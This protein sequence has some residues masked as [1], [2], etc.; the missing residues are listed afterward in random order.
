MSAFISKK[1]SLVLLLCAF[2]AAAVIVLLL[3][4]TLAGPK[5]GPIYDIL[6]GFRPS[7]PVSNDILLIETDEIIEP[8]DVFSVL[9][10]LSEMG[11]SDLLI[12]VPVLGTSSGG[13]AN[14]TELGYQISDEFNLLGRNIRNLF[15]A[16][17]M[18]L[19]SPLESP[20]F[21]ESVVELAERGRDRLNAAAIRQDEEGS[22]RAGQAA[23]VFGRVASAADLRPQPSGDIPWYSRPV[24][25]PDR[26]LRRI[27]PITAEG[28]EHIAYRALASRW[29]ES[30]VEHTE[31]GMVLVNRF[32]FQGE[33]IEYRF[34]LD[35]GGNLLFERPHKNSGFRRLP[36]ELFSEYDRTDRAMARLLKEAE[37][38]GAYSETTPEDI[39]SILYEFTDIKKEDLLQKPDD[40]MRA[41]WIRSRME[42][43]ASLEEFLYGPSEM[44]LVNGYEELI[45]GEG[46]EEEG[47]VK[48]QGLRDE[49]IRAFVGMREKHRELTDLRAL[50]A[51]ELNSSFCIMGPSFSVSEGE[52]PVATTPLA[53]ARP[54]GSGGAIPESS[55]L[56]A[57]ALLNG[58]SVTP[59]QM[60]YIVFWSLVA[61]LAVLV[62]IHAL[63]PLPLLLT[64]LAASL[65]CGLSF[66]V[67]FVAGGYWIDPLIPA[68]ACLGGTLVLAVS[69]FCIGYD[70]TL[71]FRLAYASSVNRDALKLLVKTGRPALAET[72]TA[73]AAIIAVKNQ[74]LSVI[75]DREQPLEAAVVTGEFRETFSAY[76]KNAGAQL[77]GFEG[78][79]ALACFG[80]PLDNCRDGT[81]PA[82]RA[83]QCVTKLLGDPMFDE[84]R[85]GVESGECTFSWSAETGYTA[86][87]RAAVRARIFSALAIR[88][89]AK[90]IIGEAARE[91]IG[92]KLRKLSSLGDSA[93]S[94]AAVSENFYELK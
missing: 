64:G 79:I 21:V 46:H 70:R 50:L 30:E 75:E 76:F 68:A 73:E 34:H 44:I 10:A 5:L 69:R 52:Q 58:R 14:G 9:M 56:L 54:A 65:L 28:V 12:E 7:P 84:C 6:L 81:H 19:I 74:H 80:S 2:C 42:Y 45:A 94:S 78:N 25:D 91:T 41:A 87:G 29:N 27:A 89:K 43:V 53:V 72:I 93:G 66:C 4:Y 33:E 63:G 60:M 71:R 35:S 55:A 11:A 47:I 20:V 22:E 8:G 23:V 18:G 39:P 57:N 1:L 90:A 3:N 77:L 32:R 13:L 51:Q 16:I 38:M 40:E 49:L 67:S 59:G 26:A 88:Y 17:R 83:T 37:A 92:L 36:L 61:S 82:L 86:V 24:P 31:A 15:E 62:C 48:L 85:F